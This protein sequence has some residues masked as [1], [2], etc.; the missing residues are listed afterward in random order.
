M[1]VGN[2]LPRRRNIV[3]DLKAIDLAL[4]WR[5]GGRVDRK[6]WPAE[7]GDR[8]EWNSSGK[9]SVILLHQ[10]LTLPREFTVYCIALRLNAGRIVAAASQAL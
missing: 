7:G 3:E 8:P 9:M 1:K 10:K 4:A 5:H 2:R 6:W